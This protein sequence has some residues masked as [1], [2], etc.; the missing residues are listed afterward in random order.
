MR[1]SWTVLL[2][3]LI[4]SIQGFGQERF[5]Q[6][7]EGWT[8]IS[9]E[10]KEDK[11]L[12]LSL[13]LYQNNAHDLNFIKITKQGEYESHSN[14]NFN[15]FES[16]TLFPYKH[17]FNHNKR[18]VTGIVKKQLPDESTTLA[19]AYLV[20]DEEYQDTI[21]T[22]VYDNYFNNEINTFYFSHPF[23]DS[24]LVAGLY[25]PE[26]HKHPRAMLL[27]IAPNGDV[28]WD[29][30]YQGWGCS[31]TVPYQLLPLSDGTFF[32]TMEEY[33]ES[34]PC[35]NNKETH[36]ATIV[37]I[38]SLG[39]PIHRFTV[40]DSLFC[41]IR[42]HVIPD[43]DNPNEYFVT[44]TD[45]YK[46]NPISFQH[47][48]IVNDD[49]TIWIAKIDINGNL[50]WQKKLETDL[51]EMPNKRYIISDVT[52]DGNGH[53][54]ISGYLSTSINE[55]YS[56][57]GFVIKVNDYGSG[58][59]YREFI[60]FPDNEQYDQEVKIG[61]VDITSDGGLIFTGEFI[62]YG[63]DSEM[64]PGGYQSAFVIKTD[65][66]GCLE[67]ACNP[68]C[69]NLSSPLI[70]STQKL[71]LYPNPAKEKIVVTLPEKFT[72][73]RCSVFNSQGVNC[74]QKETNNKQ[75]FQVSLDELISGYYTIR[76]WADGKLYF[77]KFVKE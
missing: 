3:L 34:C 57:R 56:L 69:D 28:I 15:Q 22:R 10:E 32:L 67:E 26:P 9:I 37:K 41:N 11:Y 58:L 18:T 54:Y 4:F 45:P 55:G 76:V 46:V 14:W 36:Y 7:L 68:D 2:V 77:G 50:L 65:S 40:G 20:F 17:A 48:A 23:G 24:I 52:W 72:N 5:H 42:P 30:Y 16:T 71:K 51:P 59:W 60:L 27:N 75:E 6:F 62:S 66:C 43:Y 70:I 38:D 33:C 61:S 12:I 13:G 39:E 47:Q 63:S 49:R 44:W 35:Q 25:N 29:Q 19:G 21:L 53:F 1:F 73:I 8:G 31:A 64:F 74:L